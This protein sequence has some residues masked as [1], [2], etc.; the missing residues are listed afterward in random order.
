MAKDGIK[1]V[2]IQTAI[3][4]CIGFQNEYWSK[5]DREQLESLTNCKYQF[6]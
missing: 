5:E 4:A 2:K 6:K 1:S 3:G